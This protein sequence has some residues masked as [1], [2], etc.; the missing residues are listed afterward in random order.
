MKAPLLNAGSG[1]GPSLPWAPLTNS[2]TYIP[3]K[4]LEHSSLKKRTIS[5][6][7]N[8]P[9]VPPLKRSSQ[10]ILGESPPANKP[11]SAPLLFR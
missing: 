10:I 2:Q 8:L 6:G 3:S 5:K 9:T 7:K 11:H 4:R 1:L